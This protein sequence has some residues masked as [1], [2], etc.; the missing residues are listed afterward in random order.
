MLDNEVKTQ[1]FVLKLFTE[2]MIKGAS[3]RKQMVGQL[4]NNLMQILKRISKDVVVKKFSDKIEVLTPIE[5]VVHVRQKLLDTPGVDFVLEATQIN[6]MN[7]LDDIKVAVNDIMG[8]EI[9]GKTFVVKFLSGYLPSIL[10]DLAFGVSL[11]Y[12]NI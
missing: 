8:K 12:S 6:Q 1:K 9:V 5:Y 2:I 7:T 11:T 10:L 3:T 4:Y